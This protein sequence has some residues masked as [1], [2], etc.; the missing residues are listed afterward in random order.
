M[1]RFVAYFNGVRLASAN[2]GSEERADAMLQEVLSLP[3]FTGGHVEA[4]VD[5]LGWVVCD[6]VGS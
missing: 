3:G 1:Y 4:K 6:H 5:G 2:V